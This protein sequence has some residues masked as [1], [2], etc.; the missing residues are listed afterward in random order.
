MA[1]PG[2]VLHLYGKRTIREGRKMGHV[3]FLAEE[4]L[5][6]EERARWLIKQLA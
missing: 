4:S 2:A 3:T 1:I 5:I 6:A